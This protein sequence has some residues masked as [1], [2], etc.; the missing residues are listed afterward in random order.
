MIC[1]SFEDTD[2]D[3]HLTSAASV[4]GPSGLTNNDLGKD[5]VG[6]IFI[7]HV[8]ENSSLAIKIARG[9]EANGYSAWYYERD[10]LPGPSYLLQ[11]A[12]EIEKS[13]AVVLIISPHSLGSHQVTKEVIRAHESGKPFIPVLSSIS[14]VEFGNRQPEWREALGSATSISV[15][16]AGVDQIIPRILDG[17]K[18]LGIAPSEA[19]T[20]NPFPESEIRSQRFIQK[21][22]AGLWSRLSGLKPP[23]R[24]LLPWIALGALVAIAST[25]GLVLSSNKPRDKDLSRKPS[26]NPLIPPVAASTTS[27]P[28]ASSQLVGKVGDLLTLAS[29]SPPRRVEVTL[30]EV[31]DPARTNKDV[32]VDP[33]NRLV[34]FRLKIKNVGNELYDDDPADLAEVV[35]AQGR[36]YQAD[37]FDIIDP[38]FGHLRMG[39]GVAIEGVIT[40]EIPKNLRLTSFV[41]PATH[42]EGDSGKWTLV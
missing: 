23:W 14:H 37:P 3:D 17:L 31:I 41:F 42:F 18:S 26:I 4:A 34:A 6:D 35:D 16:K 5:L 22:S 30:L 1:T 39:P 29:E 32:F 27:P 38:G 9:L 8:E 13:Q 7:S 28:L 15:P 19:G 11:T 2:L 36:Q 25:A 12:H 10:S 33:D 40:F 24:K 21:E 20:S